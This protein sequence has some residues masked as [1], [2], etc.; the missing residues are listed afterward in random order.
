MC[1]SDDPVLHLNKILNKVLKPYPV[2]I[3]ASEPLGMLIEGFFKSPLIL[4]P[5]RIPV[6][7]G[8]KT[9]KHLNHV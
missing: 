3:A 8:K 4:M 1:C 6:I 5:A 9:P 2:P 7:V